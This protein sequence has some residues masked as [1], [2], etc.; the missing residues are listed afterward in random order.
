MWPSLLRITAALS[1]ALAGLAATAAEKPAE[2]LA[3][4]MVNPGYEEPPEWF[5]TSF[6]DLR[7][8]VAEARAAGKRVLLYFYQDGCPY[9]AKL[10]RDNLGDR[11]IADKTRTHF[12]V[13]AI[14]MWGDR[15]VTD[16]D[17]KVMTEKQFAAANRVMFTPT[18]VF[19][20]ESGRQALRINGYYPPDKF[21]AALDYVRKKLEK[22]LSF[23]D[24]YARQAPV[25][26]K[27]KLHDQPFIIKPPY[28]LARLMRRSDKPLL[29]LFEQVQ[30][31]ACDELHE[32]IFRR[33]ETLEQI[34][35]LQVVRV[36]MWDDKSRLVTPRG[37][38][39]T[40]ARWAAALGVAY[41]PTMVFFDRDPSGKII[42]PIRM[43][44]YLKAFHI[45]SVMD[46]VASRGY[47]EQPSFQRFI[48][49][50]AD[51]LEAQGV[52]VDLWK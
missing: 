49:A 1:V 5:K 30:C 21:D 33:R 37:K 34:A 15:E 24:Y 9:C 26:A 17:G 52:H 2:A 41:A 4:G 10:L 50:R 13:I 43:E 46:Y 44:A 16:M 22:K 28:D 18:L 23:H 36:D 35:R 31:R 42:E 19:L 45:Q 8:D 11:R 6:L 38:T 48:Q 39:T 7:E 29:V 14:N 20:D 25:K 32:D 51:R 47:R 40:P 27:G 12:D 3:E